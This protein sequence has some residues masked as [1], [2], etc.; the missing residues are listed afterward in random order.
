[1]TGWRKPLK[2]TV[3][4]SLEHQAWFG[5]EQDEELRSVLLKHPE[6]LL[7]TGHTHWHLESQHTIHRAGELGPVMF[8]TASVAYLWS[9]EDVYVEGS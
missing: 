6:A 5:V 4:G 1:M 3:A 2:N 9:D 7:F 8:N